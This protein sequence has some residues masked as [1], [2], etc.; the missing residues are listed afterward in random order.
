M[1]CTFF[2]RMVRPDLEEK[3]SSIRGLP[4]KNPR[5]E[6]Q[7]EGKWTDTVD[8]KI[9]QPDSRR[10]TV[11]T[12]MTP[13]PGTRSKFGHQS[14]IKSQQEQKNNLSNFEKF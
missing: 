2:F 4:R 11:G 3:P 14:K 10:R 1:N 8:K 6:P 12:F 13:W 7:P 9:H 5:F